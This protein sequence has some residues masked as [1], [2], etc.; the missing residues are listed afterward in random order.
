MQLNHTRNLNLNLPEYEDEADIVSLNENMQTLDYTVGDLDEDIASKITQP[1]GGTAG[2]VLELGNNGEVHWGDKLP[3]GNIAEVVDD[4]LQVHMP[5]AQSF[6]VDQTLNVNGAAADARVAGDRIRAIENNINNF[7]N[8]A[9]NNQVPVADGNGGW[10]WETMSVTDG[11][12]EYT[13]PE[14]FGAAGDGVTDDTTAIQAAI[15]YGIS[16]NVAVRG[17]KQYKTTSPLTVSANFLDLYLRSITYTGNEYGLSITGQYNNVRVDLLY[18]TYGQGLVMR[19]PSGGNCAFNKVYIMR[20]FA[21]DHSIYFDTGNARYILYNTFDIRVAKSEV[22]NVYHGDDYVVENVYMNTSCYCSAGWAVYRCG[23]RF[24]N[25]TMERDVYNGIYVTAGSCYYSGCRHREMTD[26]M[27]RYINGKAEY[28]GGMLIKFVG[29]NYAIFRW[30]G[31]DAIPYECIDASEMDSPESLLAEYNSAATDTERNNA[32][33]KMSRMSFY[34]VIDAPIRIGNWDSAYGHVMLG[35]K[36]YVHGGRKICVPYTDTEYRVI[37]DMDLREAQFAS[38][39]GN[40]FPT[41]FV[42]GQTG[43]NIYLS[44]SYCPS[45]YRE[46]IVDQSGALC[47][48]YDYNDTTTPIFDGSTYGY[49]TFKLTAYANIGYN[50]IRKA[51]PSKHQ[52]FFDSSNYF[53]RVE[54]LQSSLDGIVNVALYGAV[55]D[56]VTDDSNALWQAMRDN[57]DVYLESNKTYYLAST[58]N[59]HHDVRLH[60]GENTVIKTKTPTGGVVNDALIFSGNL[61]TTTTLTSNYYYNSDTGDNALNKLTLTDMSQ[62]EIGDIVVVQATDQYYSYARQYYYLGASLLVTDVYDGHLYTNINMPFDIE[63]TANVAV[64]VYSAPKITVENINFVS[65]LDSGSAGAYKYCLTMIRCK[66]PEIRN[67]TFMDTNNGALLQQC[68]GATVENVRVAKVQRTNQSY[69][70]YSVAIYS[71]TETTI[72]KLISTGGRSAINMSGTMPS[73]NTYIKECDLYAEARSSGLGMHENVYNTIIEDCTIAGATL[74]GT[75]E[76]NRCT[77]VESARIPEVSVVSFRGSHNPEFAKIRIRDSKFPKGNGIGLVL[78]E[79]APQQPR[80]TFDNIIGSVEIYNCEG[81]RIQYTPLIT[82][83]ILSNSINQIIIDGWKDCHEFHREPSTNKIKYLSVN[84]S[85]FTHPIWLNDH[86]NHFADADITFIRRKSNY[87]Q[88]DIMSVKDNHGSKYY[89]PPNFPITFSS[90]DTHAHYRVCG[91]NIASNR[92]EDNNVGTVGGGTGE[93]LTRTPNSTFSNAL[94]VDTNLNLVFTQP[95]V[96]TASAIYPYG[97]L[98]VKDRSVLKASVKIKNTGAT[99][100]AYFRLYI[101]IID[102]DTGLIRYRGNGTGDQATAGGTVITHEREVTENSLVFVYLHCYSTTPLAQ[103]TISEYVAKVLPFDMAGVL[104]F[105]S[106]VGTSRESNGVLYSISG[107]NNIMTDSNSAVSISFVA[108]LLARTTSVVG[109]GVSF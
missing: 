108:D 73:I 44:A 15:N 61:K 27:V 54:S 51:D 84:N 10:E 38:N 5:P 62:V 14:D 17:Y 105:D 25:F 26:K 2:Q 70:A 83:T 93:A 37:S 81:G 71:C 88:V 41:K 77:F 16:H 3:T 90:E 60:G 104:V 33:D 63:N 86:R 68:V 97:M 99:A 50:C 36:M 39:H 91:S 45:G 98:Y 92:L 75:I 69:D 76:I 48:I 24:Y 82:E 20:V 89:M 103:T 95:Q 4:W 28:N 8:G 72:H 66:M 67:C 55:G 46:F 49:G 29:A 106:Y 7:A 21:H 40:T 58:I 32:L 80:R 102:A 79:P 1:P 100:G 52:P 22:G 85:T 96:S 34:Q 18:C 31:D 53:W 13:Q 12:G 42:I 56:G 65:D 35:S 57:Y 59:I 107:E 47:T 64:Y 78:R 101:C 74:Y 94:S 43:T 9:T 6:I 23:G 30:V 87:P 11:G 109:N 19:R